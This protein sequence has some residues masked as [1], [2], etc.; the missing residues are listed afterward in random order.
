MSTNPVEETRQYLSRDDSLEKVQF[1]LTLG[2]KGSEELIDLLNTQKNQEQVGVQMEMDQ[3]SI[4]DL[5]R[6]VLKD[7]ICLEKKVVGG[8]P[9]CM[10]QS[11]EVAVS[12]VVSAEKVLEISQTGESSD[13]SPT[14]KSAESFQNS[15][16]NSW[17]AVRSGELVT[18]TELEHVQKEVVIVERLIKALE[19]DNEKL[20]IERRFLKARVNELESEAVNNEAKS[21]IIASGQNVNQRLSQASSATV[22]GESQGEWFE[23]INELRVE[24]ERQRAISHELQL[25]LEL[26]QCE[27]GNSE[28]RLKGDDLKKLEDMKSQIRSLQAEI[29]RKDM[30]H[31]EMVMELNR[32]ISWYVERQEFSQSQED[33]LKEQQ[34]IIS[35]LRAKVS[36]TETTEN[37]GRNSRTKKDKQV[38]QLTK[39]IAELEET[40]KNERPDSIAQL[41]R[42]CQP[43]V[44]DT[45]LFKKLNK[46]IKE[47]EDAL[48]EKD[49]C[50]ENA[51][52]RLRVETDR[53]KL[54]Y[55]ER[56]EKL[57]EELKLKLLQAQSRRV[58]ELE[59]QL[60]ST[61][62]ELCERER[63]KSVSLHVDVEAAD[64]RNTDD[65]IQPKN[66]LLVTSKEAVENKTLVATSANDVGNLIELKLRKENEMLRNE[67]TQLKKMG[68]YPLSSLAPVN[69]LSVATSESLV[70]SLHAQ[71]SSLTSELLSYKRL[72][73]ESQEALRDLYTRRDDRLLMAKEEHN[74]QL[75]RIRE[76]HNSDIERIQEQHK[77]EMRSIVEQCRV[78]GEKSCIRKILAQLPDDKLCSRA[79]LQ[80]VADRLVAL[81]QQ[82]VQREREVVRE[83]SE[84]KRV[85]DFEIALVKQKSEMLLEEK[86]QQIQDFQL[87][88]DQLLTGLTLLQSRS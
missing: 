70:S 51:V 12:S 61:Q 41:I 73:S 20:H 40:L 13:K 33:L 34:Q 81:E 52:N 85:A 60:A 28:A 14:R 43:S 7:G 3:L 86:N 57:E 19:E 83:I 88:L 63:G 79:F 6:G 66:D 48:K 80:R 30:E 29:K 56:I 54:Q 42:S 21:S 69:T 50:A 82:Q 53:M 39:R 72:L 1:V 36:E 26:A 8:L 44:E 5:D 77:Q 4:V 38:Q 71:I 37:D 31:G 78:M 16:N 35:H 62:Q 67:L 22:V 47:L 32:K 46:R 65:T 18:R 2:E 27:K 64:S 49:R 74:A 76:M 58:R 9:S 10:V 15:R 68:E 24:L 87:Q 84:I 55:Q 75:H 11:E 17:K 45:K 59:K 25:A 23:Q